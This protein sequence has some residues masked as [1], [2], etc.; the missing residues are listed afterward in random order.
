M[1]N[2][3]WK[4]KRD[5]ENITELMEKMAGDFPD[6]SYYGF[7]DKF[8][9]SHPQLKQELIKQGYFTCIGKDM[10]GSDH[11]ILGPTGIQW[12]NTQKTIESTESIRRMTF[13]LVI[14][15][16]IIAILTTIPLLREI[17]LP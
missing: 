9:Q 8:T 13:W 11:Y 10:L 1:K 6:Y 17:F 12:V 15:T 4:K 2:K 16:I 3:F 5:P 14:F 7:L